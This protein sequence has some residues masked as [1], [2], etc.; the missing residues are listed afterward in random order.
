MKDTRL[1]MFMELIDEEIE[2]GAILEAIVEG[3]VSVRLQIAT[4]LFVVSEFFVS[5]SSIF[6]IGSIAKRE[7]LDT[8]W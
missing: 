8:N 3:G 4:L 1:G 7:R 6:F 2:D 5:S